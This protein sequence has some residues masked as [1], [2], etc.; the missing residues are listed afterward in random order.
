MRRK[1]RQMKEKKKAFAS[2]YLKLN[3]KYSSNKIPLKKHFKTEAV[4]VLV[5]CVCTVL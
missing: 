3:K 5:R 2:F 1:T 4:S